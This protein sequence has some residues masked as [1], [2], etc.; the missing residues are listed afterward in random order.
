MNNAPESPSRIATSLT[1]RAVKFLS[2]FLNIC[3]RFLIRISAFLR[4]EIFEI[5]RQPLLVLTLVLGPFLILLFFGIGYRNEP[6]AL[7]TMFV[8]EENN[9]LAQRI[10]QDASSLGKQLIFAGVTDSL[11]IAQENLRQ[12][13]IDLITVVPANAYDTI[14]N[15][16]QAAFQVY[17]RE[18]DPF[19]VDYINVFAQVYIETV[20]R[21]ILYFIT[22]EG[23]T[24]IS[25]AREKLEAARTSAGAL[26]E[27]LEGCAAVLGQ[28]GSEEECDTE[29]ARQHLQNLDQNVDELEL[30]VRDN[31]ALVEAIER[32]LNREIGNS[33][34]NETWPRLANII[35]DSNEL[36]ALELESGKLQEVEARTNNYI[37][38]LQTLAK[39]EGDLMTVEMR[40]TEFV[41]IDPIVLISPFRSEARSIATIGT[42]ITAFFAPAVIV[43][44]LQ[45]LTVTF[46]A[47]SMVRERQLGSMELFN[48]SPLS[49]VETL[50]GKYLSYLLFGGVLALILFALVIFGMGVPILGSPFSAGLVIIILL[51]ASLGIGFVISSLSNT[52]IQ[53]VQ[54]SM[55]VLLTS[56]FFSGFL[57][58]LETLWEPVRIISWSLPA[59]YGIQLLRDIMLRGDP[60]AF[61][62]LFQLTV[63]GLGLFLLA[64]W[65]LRRS[66]VRI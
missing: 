18:I 45:H 10:E 7:R 58:G 32:E 38:Q 41:D 44:L 54:Y 8:V 14:R 47:L 59:T 30:A 36:W 23:Q 43:L 49:A 5:V 62:L 3:S 35:R 1:A 4:K 50:L 52:D 56:V 21:R 19:Q 9:L 65:L 66:M 31:V 33:S 17:H 57:L 51:F 24:N 61:T 34:N 64:W 39:L 63:I 13:E 55:I 28:P 37:A 48:V 53:A 2:Q 25:A 12:G 22:A 16:Q 27:L 15:S 6:R 46:G 40:L 20:N 29:T 42:G 26:R 11:E 60:P